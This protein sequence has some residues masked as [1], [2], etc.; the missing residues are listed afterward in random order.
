[1]TTNDLDLLNALADKAHN[2]NV[3]VN[4]LKE[5]NL[6]IIRLLI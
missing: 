2:D 6:D 1:M 3:T 5:F 4:E